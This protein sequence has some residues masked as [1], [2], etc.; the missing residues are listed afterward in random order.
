[1]KNKRAGTNHMK[2]S[3]KFCVLSGHTEIQCESKMTKSLSG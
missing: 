1:M 2:Y 3:K